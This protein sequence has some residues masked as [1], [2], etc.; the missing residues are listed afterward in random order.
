[1]SPEAVTGFSG[2]PGDASKSSN[3]AHPQGATPSTDLWAFGA[4]VYILHTGSCPF[5]SPS[6]YL[7]FLRIKRGLL[8]RNDWALPDETWDYCRSLMEVDPSKR[9]GAGCYQ[10]SGGKMIVG[11]NYDVLR[12]HPYFEGIRSTKE[13]ES[14]VIASLQDL[15]LRACVEL[16]RKDAM[17]MEIC[18]NHPPGDG[19]SHDM[20]RIQDDQR[21]LILHYLDKCKVFKDGDETRVFQRF[22]ADD[23]EYLRAKVRSSSRDF[24]GLTQMNDDEYKPQTQ[25]GSQDPY[26]KKEKP[27]PTNVFI[28]RNPR[29]VDGQETTDDEN[30]SWLKGWKNSIAV[31]NKQR[32]KIVVA[33][34]ATIPPKYWKFLARVR[35]SIHVIWNDGSRFYSFWIHGFQGIAQ[36]LTDNIGITLTP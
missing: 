4:V 29:L 34:A 10:E 1:M 11:S 28:L 35:D 26:A 7:T 25:R 23:I 20:L 3:S 21:K 14:H 8:P 16:V 5:W 33:C 24:V 30:K 9:L 27:Q 19:S 18:E 15:A 36:N 2:M 13:D 12:N 22:F 32:P 17:D 31:V 6:P